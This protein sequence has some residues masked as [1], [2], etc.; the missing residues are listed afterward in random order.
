MAARPIAESFE[1]TGFQKFLTF[2]SEKQTVVRFVFQNF[3]PCHSFSFLTIIR[4]LLNYPYNPVKRLVQTHLPS[5]RPAAARICSRESWLSSLSFR[6][7]P[8]PFPYNRGCSILKRRCLW[9]LKNNYYVSCSKIPFFPY[10]LTRGRKMGTIGYYEG[11][12]P[13]GD[14]SRLIFKFYFAEVLK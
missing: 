10:Y 14:I 12:W 2:S 4:K 7:S 8:P 13:L 6:H 9:L 1:L 11:I 3:I 5:T